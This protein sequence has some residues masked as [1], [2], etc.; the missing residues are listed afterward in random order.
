M[1]IFDKAKAMVSGNKDKSKQGVE[2]AAGEAK[3]V[4]PDQH[5]KQVDQAAKAADEAI[6]KLD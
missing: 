5:D 6:D 3:K 4:V 2:V 1:G